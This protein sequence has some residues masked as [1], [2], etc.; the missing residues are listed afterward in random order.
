MLE[1][2]INLPRKFKR[3]LPVILAK[4]P[5]ASPKDRRR[6]RIEILA[7]VNE[8][9]D[10]TERILSP[11]FT[12]DLFRYV[13]AIFDM[14]IEQALLDTFTLY[15]QNKREP[16]FNRLTFYNID[17]KTASPYGLHM[18]CPHNSCFNL[19]HDTYEGAIPCTDSESAIFSTD[20]IDNVNN[21]NIN[22]N[23]ITLATQAAATSLS[24]NLSLQQI[25]S[26]KKP[27]TPTD[28]DSMSAAPTVTSTPPNAASHANPPAAVTAYLAPTAT[29][30]KRKRSNSPQ[31]EALSLY[32]SSDSSFPSPSKR[33]PTPSY[34]SSS[35][36]GDWNLAFDRATQQYH[37][38]PHINESFGASM[39][40][41]MDDTIITPVSLPTDYWT[42]DP[43]FQAT[44]PNPSAVRDFTEEPRSSTDSPT[45]ASITNIPSA[46]RKTT[47]PTEPANTT[48]TSKRATA[49]FSPKLQEL[50]ALLFFRYQPLLHLNGNQLGRVAARDP[51][52]DLLLIHHGVSQSQLREKFKALK[53][54]C[55]ERSLKTTILNAA[56]AFL[57]YYNSQL[58]TAFPLA[59]ELSPQDPPLPIALD[60]AIVFAKYSNGAN[61][62]EYHARLESCPSYGEHFQLKFENQFN[63][64]IYEN[65]HILVGIHG[66]VHIPITP[67]NLPTI[68]TTPKPAY[69]WATSMHDPA[70]P[71]PTPQHQTQ[72]PSAPSE[73]AANPEEHAEEDAE[74]DTETELTDIRP[75]FESATH[76][77]LAKE[78]QQVT[79]FHTT[80]G[81][82]RF[83][84]VHADLQRNPHITP[85]IRAQFHLP[86]AWLC[87][88]YPGVN[89]EETTGPKNGQFIT[90]LRDNLMLSGHEEMDQFTK[91]LCES[92]NS[93]NPPSQWNIRI[94]AVLRE[95]NFVFYLVVNDNTRTQPWSTLRHPPYR[96]ELSSRLLFTVGRSPDDCYELFTGEANSYHPSRCTKK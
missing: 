12:R 24:T 87:C 30:F 43:T 4:G 47:T 13:A 5:S 58:G 52:V 55:N 81:R 17:I 50:V 18:K 90:P 3:P 21:E 88:P 92:P 76:P 75:S 16:G 60:N 80:V 39:T 89:L 28:S 48:P 93:D 35:S 29:D 56:P 10:V 49:V 79:C 15:D 73:P 85:L 69:N 1:V 95:P 44:L 23:L 33:I 31:L 40:F 63:R 8:I 70:I 38:R 59:L 91:D 74:A 51:Q 78:L 66:F 72:R 36:D 20:S 14:P 25:R 45:S 67:A 53:K 64:F 65:A 54:L 9:F 62:F 77:T 96:A 42:R 11:N 86:Y 61:Y 32:G 27:H 57:E 82:R 26:P 2:W 41:A 19:D 46:R 68:K 37:M 6:I 7:M 34:S 94:E 84:N 22:T 83:V 71:A